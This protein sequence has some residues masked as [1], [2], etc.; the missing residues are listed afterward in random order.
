MPLC[1]GFL[2]GVHSTNRGGGNYFQDSLIVIKYLC[3]CIMAILRLAGFITLRVERE[4]FPR[5]LDRNQVFVP[6]YHGSL[7]LS[8]IHHFTR[9]GG[10]H[11]QD[12]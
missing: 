9:G 7:A 12:S 4:S 6:V 5:R 11:F 10:N 3:Q 1:H 2:H 8:R